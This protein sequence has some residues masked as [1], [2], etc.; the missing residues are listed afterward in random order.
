MAKQGTVAR[1]AGN[2]AFGFIK[3]DGDGPDV[4]FRL[5]WIK[6]ASVTVG[7]RVEYETRETPQGLQTSWVK[8]VGQSRTTPTQKP[9]SDTRLQGGTARSQISEDYRFLNPY[10]FVRPLKAAKPNEAP[11]LGNCPPPPHDRYLGLSGRIKCKITT[12]TPL[13]IADS[14]SIE[15]KTVG[16]KGKEKEH[17]TYHFFRYK[18]DQG[19][20]EIALPA[21]SLRGMLRATYEAATNS[22][23]SVFSG[24]K[25]LSYHLP[26]EDALKLIPARVVY[27]GGQWYLD[28][29]NGMTT[30]NIGEKPAGPQYAAWIMQYTPLRPSRTKDRAPHS[31]YSARRTISLSGLQHEAP[32]EA[33]VELVKHPLRNFEFWNV[34]QVGPSGS[35]LKPRKSDQKVVQGYLCITNQNIQ[36]KHDERVFFAAGSPVRI[37]LLDT[38]RQRYAELIKDYQERHAD[39]VQKRLKRHEKNASVPL[40]EEPEGDEAAF[41]RFILNPAETELHDGSLVYVMLEPAG[42]TARVAFIVPVSV[43]RVGYEQ[44]IADRLDPTAK[45]SDLHK[46]YRYDALCPACRVFGW[47]YGSDDPSMPELASE[48]LAAYA[49]RI[50]LTHGKAKLPVKTFDATLAILSSPKPTTTRFYLRPMNGTDPRDSQDDFQVSYNEEAH[51][52]LRGRKFYRHQ[53]IQCRTQ[54]YSSPDGKETDQNRTLKDIVQAGST[55]EFEITFEN[56]AEVELGALLWTLE[57]EGWHHRLGFAKPLGFGSLRIDVEEF[58]LLNV[59]ARYEELTLGWTP[60]ISEK[61]IYVEKFKTAMKARYGRDFNDLD[62]IR[63]LRAL[64]AVSPDLP[65]HYPRSSQE[66][67]PDGKNYEWFMG[68]KRKGGPRL[69]L[70]LSPKDKEGFPLIDKSG[71]LV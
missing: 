13:F 4:Y 7:L 33:I 27:T 70:P 6:D 46:C 31:P 5:Q 48:E 25:R 69:T 50:S 55:F 65:V 11:L 39:E 9:V 40:P 38:V 24:Y 15:S 62:N 51:Q 53:G 58:D 21:S 30:V 49:G 35:H 29:L 23:F 3:Q 44:T 16:E 32:C 41:S 10:N 66:P 37:P 12:Q 1:I 43:P 17:P 71:E 68:N 19:K 20:D 28:I 52:Q 67:Q 64:L 42:R 26:P 61:A 14:H 45:E 2:G 56:L 8:A 63:D 34:V 18:N 60:V 59:Q 47:V 54:G 57:L 36:N 22:C